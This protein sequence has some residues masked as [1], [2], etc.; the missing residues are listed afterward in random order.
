MIWESCYWKEPL[1]RTAER[2]RGLKASVELS[3]EDLANLEREIFVGFYSVRKLIEAI[4]KLTD[5]TKL[6]QVT[7]S[8]YQNIKP[9]SWLNNHKIDELYD[10][11]NEHQDIHDLSRTA[12][13][14]G[15]E[16]WVRA[17]C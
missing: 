9:V 10:L 13:E 2:L 15:P 7:V 4:T 6:F 8:W 3:E 12:G 5:R 1:L 11:K 16:G 14:G 17:A